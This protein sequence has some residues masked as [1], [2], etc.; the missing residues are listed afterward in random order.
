MKMH[1]RL[2]GVDSYVDMNSKFNMHCVDLA[3]KMN[4]NCEVTFPNLEV[5]NEPL[6][7]DDT[8]SCL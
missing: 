3:L 6:T 8:F 5:V 4:D 1:I 7:S 2:I